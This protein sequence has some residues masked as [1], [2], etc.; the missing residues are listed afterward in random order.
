MRGRE[1]VSASGQFARVLAASGEQVT[2]PIGDSSWEESV[3]DLPYNLLRV[4]VQVPTGADQLVHLHSGISSA[5]GTEDETPADVQF[6]GLM[7]RLTKCI[8]RTSILPWQRP[9]AHV[10]NGCMLVQRSGKTAS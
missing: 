5:A 7:Q 1:A 9:W 2:R 8:N 3:A 10:V 4:V 6:V